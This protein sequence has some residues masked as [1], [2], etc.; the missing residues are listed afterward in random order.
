MRGPAVLLALL[1]GVAAALPA[2]AGPLGV[3]LSDPRDRAH[4]SALYGA[5]R[6]AGRDLRDLGLTLPGVRLEAASS[7][8]DFARRTG[9]P[10][11]VAAT[12]RNGVIH[13]QRLGALA[14]ANRLRFTVRHE[15]FHAAQPR[16]LPRWL[17]EG[18]ARLFSGEAARDPQ[19]ATGLEHVPEAKLNTLL[20][21]RNESGLT[22]AYREATRRARR[23]VAARGW[24][25]VLRLN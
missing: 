19:T 22:A 9:E 23:L 1:L 8:D 17:A 10:W 21:L 4:L 13:T 12:T 7:A 6:E 20:A 3:T 11:F 16:A 24:A 5:W 18:L 14:A 2:R 25:G 15:A